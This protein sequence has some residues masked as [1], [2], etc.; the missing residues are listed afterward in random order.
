VT[1]TLLLA[2]ALAACGGPPAADAPRA[3]ADGAALFH[4]KCNQCH[5][6]PDRAKYTPAQWG[7]IL[8]EMGRRAGLTPSERDAVF[9]YVVS[10][11]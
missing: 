11:D 10:S 6:Y 2:L 4:A 7:R 9:E 5:G 3:T 8:T 1:R